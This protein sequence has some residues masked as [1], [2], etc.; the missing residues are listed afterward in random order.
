MFHLDTVHSLTLTKEVQSSVVVQYG[1][2]TKKEELRLPTY[3]C[4]AIPG[5]KVISSGCGCAAPACNYVTKTRAT[6]TSHCSMTHPGEGWGRE[7]IEDLHLQAI[8]CGHPH[9]IQVAKPTPQAPDATNASLLDIFLSNRPLRPPP[10]PPTIRETPP[11]LRKLGWAHRLAQLSE[12]QGVALRASCALP[13]YRHWSY[14]CH[15]AFLDYLLL[16]AKSITV[17]PQ[18]VARLLRS[19]SR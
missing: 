17:L 6:V 14:N 1:L 3:P 13:D 19:K 15:D 5:V 12:D 11:W 2:P 10:P 8:Y 7:I 9:Y 4:K 16:A 18:L